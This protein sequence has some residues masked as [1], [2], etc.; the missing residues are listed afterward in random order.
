MQAGY[1]YEDSLIPI[2]RSLRADN[3]AAFDRTPAP[4]LSYI[5]RMLSAIKAV[6]VVTIDEDVLL[7]IQHYAVFSDVYWCWD[8]D[9][10]EAA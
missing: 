1:E 6:A 10:I 4:N 9:K 5:P 7:N 8:Q 3:S 2:V